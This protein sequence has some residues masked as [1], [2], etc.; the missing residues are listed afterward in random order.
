MKYIKSLKDNVHLCLNICSS[1]KNGAASR[2]EHL[3]NVNK[4]MMKRINKYHKGTVLVS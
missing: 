1:P 2:K 3:K 4:L